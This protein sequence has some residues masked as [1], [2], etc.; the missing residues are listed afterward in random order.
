MEQTALPLRPESFM[1]RAMNGIARR[2]RWLI[3]FLPAAA[4]AQIDPVKRELVQFGY[5]QPLEG[6]APVAG[7]AFYYHNQP[8][9]LRTNLTWR[10]ALA[11]VYLDTEL[12]FVHGLGPNTDFA[13][14]L[15]G[16]GFAD[17]Y[18]EIRGGRWI[19]AESYDGHGAELSGSVYHLFN[20][21]QLVPLNGVLR[22][23][24]HYSDYARNSDTAAN[25]KPPTDQAAFH[26]RT[27]LRWGGE[28]PTLF[29]AVAMEISVWYEGQFRTHPGGYGFNGDRDLESNSHLFWARA[30]LDYTLPDSQQNFSLTLTAGA[31][32]DAD[33]FSAY[34]LGSLLPLGAEFPLDL[35]GYYYQELSARKFALLGGNYSVPLDAKKRWSLQATA[36]TATV[37]Y[38]PGVEESGH[39]HSG[40][41][42]GILYQPTSHAM[43][44]LVSYAYGVDA[45]RSESRGAHS[46]G[47][48]LQFD[49][50]HAK[51]FFHPG[52]TRQ[53]K[54]QP[55]LFD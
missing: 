43:K 51:P 36:A 54:A 4:W 5:N 44:I 14:G 26:V 18:N 52:G 55:H 27:G 41:G 9:C 7:Y 3:L 53:I 35:P 16:G 21:G 37:E 47:I 38:L 33:R 48:L 15:A 19:E 22:G 31:S 8:D 28:E 17:S 12:G 6:R 40:V 10:L 29:P 11:P 23:A 45:E 49:W 32:M 42:G 2:L 25:F 24:V 46:I 39:W 30:L 20:P 1:K 50:D 34:R 13:L